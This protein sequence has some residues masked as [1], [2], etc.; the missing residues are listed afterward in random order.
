MSVLFSGSQKCK[1]PAGHTHV[2]FLSV[3]Q[4]ELAQSEPT[5]LAQGASRHQIPPTHNHTVMLNKQAQLQ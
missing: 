5:A 2:E 3:S 1:L 4:T